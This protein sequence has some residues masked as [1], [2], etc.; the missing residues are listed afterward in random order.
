LARQVY[1][2]D[3]TSPYLLEGVPRTYEGTF[4]ALLDGRCIL[5]HGDPEF[6]GELDLTSYEGLMQG[7]K[8]GPSILPGDPDNSLKILRQ[9]EDA[10]HGGQV[11]DQE[12]EALRA[13]IVGGAPR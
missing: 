3:N 10:E 13:W 6:K 2:L 7:G 8:N 11:L 5:C 12:L 9:S 4:K 1:F